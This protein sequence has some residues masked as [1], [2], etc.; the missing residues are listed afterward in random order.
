MLLEDW[1]ELNVEYRTSSDAPNDS[2]AKLFCLVEDCKKN[3]ESDL[4]IMTNIV[5]IFI[6]VSVIAAAYK[7]LNT[8]L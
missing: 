2:K 7:A 6:H 4:L 3:D 8:M 5:V 1:C